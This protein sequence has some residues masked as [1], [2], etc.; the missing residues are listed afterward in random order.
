MKAFA[1]SQRYMPFFKVL[2]PAI[3]A[4]AQRPWMQNSSPA[5]AAIADPEMYF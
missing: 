1:I 4:A 2:S 3:Y 5:C